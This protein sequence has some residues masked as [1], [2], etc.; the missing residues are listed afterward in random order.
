MDYF[1]KIATILSKSAKNTLFARKKEAKL[2]FLS[3]FYYIF[4]LYEYQHKNQ[5]QFAH[6]YSMLASG[7]EHVPHHLVWTPI[8]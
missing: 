4:N 1:L 3:H 5:S 8:S 2:G 6:F 7:L